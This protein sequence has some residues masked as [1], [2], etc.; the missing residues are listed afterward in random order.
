MAAES[1]SLPDPYYLSLFA[2][3]SLLMRGAGCTINDMID[4]DFDAKVSM[5]PILSL[6][7][8]YV[9]IFFFVRE[10]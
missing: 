8:I 9:N 4:K 10:V 5:L 7:L 2:L 1:G 3:G 6:K